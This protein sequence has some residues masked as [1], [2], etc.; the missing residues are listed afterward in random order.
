MYKFNFSRLW[1]DIQY[2]LFI[3]YLIL[4]VETKGTLSIPL[5][6]VTLTIFLGLI[7]TKIYQ[8]FFNREKFSYIKKNY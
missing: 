5:I 2:P 1:K 8:Y 3:A 6:K 7:L 4:L